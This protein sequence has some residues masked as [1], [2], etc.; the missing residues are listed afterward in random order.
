[1]SNKIYHLSDGVI[2]SVG[3]MSN[4]LLNVE[5]D[6]EVKV[7]Y[8]YIE[9]LEKLSMGWDMEG[10]ESF[11][12]RLLRDNVITEGMPDGP[13][14]VLQER[15]LKIDDVFMHT[16]RDSL[17]ERALKAYDV[18]TN[19]HSRRKRFYERVG[20][21]PVLP[22]TALR[23]ALLVGDADEVGVKDVLCM[24]DDDLVSL[25][26]QALG[27]RVTVYD[28]DQYLLNFLRSLTAEL[29]IEMDIVERDLR[30]PLEEGEANRFDVF[31]TDPMSN[32]DCLEIFLSRAFAMLRVGG[33]G[34]S[35]VYGPV[36]QLFE[37]ISKEMKF[38]IKAWHAG[39]NRYY[40]KYFKLHHYESD[41]VEIEKTAETTLSHAEDAFS[42]PLNLYRED[43]Y[44]RDKSIILN[45]DNIDEP[46][47]ANPLYLN[48]VLDSLQNISGWDLGERVQ[49]LGQDWTLIHCPIRPKAG[50]KALKPGY[51]NIHSDRKRRQISVDLYP[52]NTDLE[53]ILRDLMMAG[54]K[55]NTE[56]YS[57][58]VGRAGWDVRVR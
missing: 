14:L 7:D 45:Y 2:A 13:D 56:G 29:G 39:H 20:Q 44:Q 34:F 47:F 12:P 30:D 10:F 18:L 43:Y 19:A 49:H 52:L 17:S 40:S 53:K 58:A 38:P 54:Y 6:T 32:R 48:I 27:H 35:A 55:T 46:K 1:M 26:L 41:W 57:V 4:Y 16:Y 3:P 33:T 9:P 51:L 15:L 11:V 25:A 23:R 37:T 24:G 8:R 31:L 21:C 28:I 50:S 22:E 5:D 36:S 42:V